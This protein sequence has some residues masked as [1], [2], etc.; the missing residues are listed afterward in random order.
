[1]ELLKGKVA[2]VTGGSRGIGF[3]IVKKFLENGARV[4]L[5]GSRQETAER[6]VE[7]LK[8]ENKILV[9]LAFYSISLG[10]WKNFQ[11]LWLQDNNMDISSI[12]KILSA[13]G[14]F[15]AIA[16]LIFSNKITLNKIKKVKRKRV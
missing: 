7:K 12:S 13:S 9:M 5:C 8:E 6:A 1:M 15:C 10:I 11:Q 2:V 4:I 16:L 3:A 14:L